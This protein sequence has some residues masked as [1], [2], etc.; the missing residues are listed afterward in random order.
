MTNRIFIFLVLVTLT[1]VV[2]AQSG[3]IVPAAEKTGDGAVELTLKQMFDEAN[4]YAVAKYTEFQQKKIP[5][6]DKLHDQTKLEQRQLAAKYAAQAGTR[7]GLAGDDFYFLG[8]LHWIAENMQGTAENL[9]KF[10]A[11]ENAAPDRA[12][13]ARSIGVVA[14]AKQTRMA[15]AEKLLAEY[16]SKAPLRPAEVLR[17]SAEMAKAYKIQKD[18]AK[19]APHA[20]VAYSTAVKLLSTTTSPAQST[21]EILDAGMLVFEAY[22]DLGERQRAEA[23][24]DDLRRLAVVSRSST[25]YY[26]SVDKKILYLMDTGRKKEALA[27]FRSTME[28]IPKDFA[29]KG[30]QEDLERRFR[31]RE[32]HY[33]LLGEKAP[34]LPAIDQWFPGTQRSL[35]DYRGKVVLLDFW[36]TWCGPC[37]G[38][39][40][41]FKD[42]L[43]EFGKDGFEILGSTL[44]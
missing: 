44:R 10:S 39:F 27:L 22:R 18:F 30:W 20:D 24:L 16:K 25:F 35:A 11:W 38:E 14:L 32:K 37:Y 8:M 31:Q 29:D 4:G 1:T 34:D 3:R 40:P 42:W 26:Y 23:A 2:P 12:Q 19:M 9:T 15:D 41:E 6:S 43:R 21:D 17:M 13:N 33:A 28:S 5:Y 36:A 7:A